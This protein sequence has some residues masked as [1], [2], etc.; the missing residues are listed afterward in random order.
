MT[1]R[2]DP[3]LRPVGDAAHVLNG[4][5]THGDFFGALTASLVGLR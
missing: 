4:L 1:L 5:R 2:A 3:S